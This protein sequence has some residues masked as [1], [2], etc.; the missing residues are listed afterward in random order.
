VLVTPY[1]WGSPTWL[2]TSTS[3]VSRSIWRPH[4]SRSPSKRGARWTRKAVNRQ[5][6]HTMRGV[7]NGERSDLDKRGTTVICVLGHARTTSR[8]GRTVRRRGSGSRN[9]NMWHEEKSRGAKKSEKNHMPDN[10]VYVIYSQSFYKN[11]DLLI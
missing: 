1:S 8:A 11:V 5:V 9:P 10:L 4:M 3:T 7:G 2:P 6:G